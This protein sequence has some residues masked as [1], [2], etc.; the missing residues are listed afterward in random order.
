MVLPKNLFAQVG[1][2]GHL[3]SAVIGPDPENAP[4]HVARPDISQVIGLDVSDQVIK[5]LDI[6]VMDI[7][8]P[9]LA[10]NHQ[11]GVGALDEQ[12]AVHGI[13][14]DREGA[15]LA[16]NLAD[17]LPFDQEGPLVMAHP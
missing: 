14:A 8:I 6:F 5:P 13:I 4:V 17:V 9:L 10:V 12:V 1:H 16:R 3:V 2:P 15:R 11:V 7:G